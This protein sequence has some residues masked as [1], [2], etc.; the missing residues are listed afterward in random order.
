MR[1]QTN[2]YTKDDQIFIYQM[3]IF[4][5]EG[6]SYPFIGKLFNK[7]H[8]TVIHWCKRFKVDKGTQIPTVAEFDSIL[9]KRIP[10]IKDK[11]SYILYEPVNPGKKSYA[12]YLP[13][14]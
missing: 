14:Q 12:A 8:S 11:Y 7:D 1:K 13:Q 6:N 3:L 5:S 9:N 4:R 2:R 10:E